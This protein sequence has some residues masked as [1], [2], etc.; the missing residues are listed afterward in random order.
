MG[1]VVLSACEYFDGLQAFCPELRR[2]DAEVFLEDAGKI[3]FI[4]KAEAIGHFF[5][6]ER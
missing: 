6:G 2:A 3:E 1:K 5:D 4:F